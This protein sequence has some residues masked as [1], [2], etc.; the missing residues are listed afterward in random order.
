MRRARIIAI[1]I[2]N[3]LTIEIR[4]WA[5]DKITITMSPRITMPDFPFMIV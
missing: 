1:G 5:M 2:I 4:D 3:A